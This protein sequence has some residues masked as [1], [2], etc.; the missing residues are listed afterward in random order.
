MSV[1]A[2]KEFLKQVKVNVPPSIIQREQLLELAKAAVQL[3]E[4][5]R[6]LRCAHIG[7]LHPS[8]R[9][10]AALAVFRQQSHKAGA[11]TSAAAE[12][13]ER[14]ALKR[15]CTQ[16]QLALHPDKTPQQL[17]GQQA[18]FAEAFKA[19]QNAQQLVPALSS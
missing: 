3:W 2:L 18:V 17:A 11:A 15:V 10:P 7:Q 19:L 12:E 5:Q 13:E 9:L 16:L 6:V 4:A 1:G 14:R 8:L